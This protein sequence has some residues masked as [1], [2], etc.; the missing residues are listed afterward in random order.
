M[1][2]KDHHATTIL[3]QGQST[4][5]YACHGQ[6]KSTATIPLCRRPHHLLLPLQRYAARRGHIWRSFGDKTKTDDISQKDK[7]C[8]FVRNRVMGGRCYHEGGKEE[9]AM[10]ERFR[11]QTKS[12]LEQEDWKQRAS[13]W[14]W[15]EIYSNHPLKVGINSMRGSCNPSVS[16]LVWVRR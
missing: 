5:R 10:V 9:E 15:L 14:N 6:P 4:R 3:G 8:C 1:F 16:S 12:K 11:A 13:G 2:S 7:F